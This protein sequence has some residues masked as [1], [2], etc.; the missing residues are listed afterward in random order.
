MPAGLQILPPLQQQQAPQPLAPL[1]LVQA[2]QPVQPSQNVQQDHQDVGQNDQE[3][4]SNDKNE[5]ADYD[6]WHP[7]LGNDNL[8][9]D[10]VL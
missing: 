2:P 3:M 6:D 8:N 7:D 5:P 1:Q 9:I 10:L 4:M